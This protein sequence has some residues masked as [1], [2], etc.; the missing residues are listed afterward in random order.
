MP[1]FR[2]TENILKDKSA[3]DYFDPNWMDAGGLAL[4]PNPKWDYSRELQIEDIDLWEVIME[5]GPYGVYAAWCPYAEFYLILLPSGIETFYGVGAE[6]RVRRCLE[7]NGIQ[8]GL[9]SI[10]VDQED[11]YL[12]K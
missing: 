6:K 8:Y 12:Y 10:W 3:S 4:P 11:M 5:S 2:T 1:L 7:A 9:N